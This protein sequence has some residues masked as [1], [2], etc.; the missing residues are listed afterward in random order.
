VLLQ[1]AA[2]NL[3]NLHIQSRTCVKLLRRERVKVLTSSEIDLW[4]AQRGVERE[5]VE[6]TRYGPEGASLYGIPQE[7]GRQVALARLVAGVLDGTRTYLWIQDTEVY[8]SCGNPFAFGLLRR[9]LGEER[10]IYEAPFHVFEA[11]ESDALEALLCPC[12]H[13]SWDF[14]VGDEHGQLIFAFDHDDGMALRGSDSAKRAEID[15]Y[16]CDEFKLTRLR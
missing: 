13:Y 2:L 15:A 10:D 14:F 3:L 1:R 6:E 12:E 9:A 8:P 16:L 5:T 11:D 7:A 4:F